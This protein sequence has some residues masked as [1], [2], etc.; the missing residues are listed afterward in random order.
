[1][2]KKKL[3]VCDYGNPHDYTFPNFDMGSS[4]KR[5]W[6]FAKSA[7]ELPDIDVV[8]TG[9]LW[10]PQYVPKAKYFPKR[11]S[12]ETVDE[13]IAE[14][15]TFDYLFAGHE[16]FDKEEWVSAFTKC[17]RVLLSYQL[18]PY[19]YSKVS[20]NG[21]NKILFCYSDEMLKMYAEQKPVKA[22]LFHSGVN[23]EPLFFKD[24]EPHILWFGRIDPEKAP[25]YAI[26]ASKYFDLPLKMMGKPVADS[27]YIEK[28][29]RDYDCSN[30]EFVGFLS[31]REKMEMLGKASCVLYTVDKAFREAGAGIFGEALSSGVPVAGMTW[32]GDDALCDAVTS[33]E[34]GRI[35]RAS[36]L[37]DEMIPRALAGAVKECLALK[38]LKIKEF[39]LST[40][41]PVKLV[42]ELLKTAD[43]LSQ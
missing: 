43:E 7:S 30:V 40:Y 20:F 24:P 13:F 35:V 38:R 28:L 18:H 33:G 36:E 42:E 27:D 3:V 14:Y 19:E 32:V 1:M 12:L 37:S 6:H 2:D 10:L 31:G 29:K 41:D 25:H 11:L 8:I 9:P 39:G 17:A 34:V 26:L 4:E 21:S 15:G 5:L 16:Y 23:E 22:K